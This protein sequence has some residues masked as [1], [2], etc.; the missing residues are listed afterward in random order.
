LDFP[1]AGRFYVVLVSAERRALARTA[2]AFRA[3]VGFV[4]LR[5]LIIHDLQIFISQERIMQRV[6]L[7]ISA[8]VLLSSVNLIVAP[9][10]IAAGVNCSYE[11][12]IKQ[13]TKGATPNGCSKWCTDAMTERRNAGQCKK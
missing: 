3:A 7:A 4:M 1:A 9:S 10:V 13:C 5:P 6:S 8:V 2:P 11:A 12:C